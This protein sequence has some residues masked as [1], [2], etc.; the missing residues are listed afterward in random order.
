MLTSK[1][2]AVPEETAETS[3]SD[4][5]PGRTPDAP[6]EAPK[7]PPPAATFRQ[8]VSA[9]FWSFFGVR[10]GKAMQ[11]D[12]VTI[13]PHQVILVGIVIAAMLVVAL[14]VLVRTITRGL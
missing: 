14:I 2:K 6:P 10:K 12:A 13:R 1:A 4:A 5:K 3:M 9:V 7:P 8:V 11:R